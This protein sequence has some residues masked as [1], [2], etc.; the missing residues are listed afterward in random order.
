[1]PSGQL[2]LLGGDGASLDAIEG[3][4][5]AGPF[6]TALP[7]ERHGHG[8]AVVQARPVQVAAEHGKRLRPFDCRP[9]SFSIPFIHI[10]RHSDADASEARQP[11]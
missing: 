7:V 11:A 3:D 9:E 2:P 5:A 6:R 8:A 1:M 10:H 4:G